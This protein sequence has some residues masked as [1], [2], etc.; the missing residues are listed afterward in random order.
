MQAHTSARVSVELSK[1]C[2]GK[3]RSKPVWVMRYRLPSGK[4][5]R[6]VLGPAWQKKGRP[7]HGYL[8][9]GEALV[10]AEAFS[11]EHSTVADEHPW[12]LPLRAGHLPS[13]LRKGEG[14]PRLYAARVPED[15]RA[16]G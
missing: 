1:T 13:V 8:T 4:D 11:A 7:P 16:I 6:K 9:E 2:K 14:A 3:P 12:H 10:K 5:S 15:R